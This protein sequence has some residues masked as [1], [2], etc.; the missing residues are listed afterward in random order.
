MYTLTLT[1]LAYIVALDKHRNFSLAAE[2]CHVTQPTLSM[3]VQKLEED[4]GLILFDRSERPI[5]PTRIG[6]RVIAQARNVLAETER[7][8]AIAE[9]ATGEMKG[10]LR[11]GIISTL[12]PYLLPL[13]ITPFARRYPRVSLVFEEHVAE[14]ITEYLRRD[15]LDVGLV[16][17]PAPESGIIEDPLFS[18]P[19]VGY[20]SRA[21]RLYDKERITVDDLRTDQ[22]WLMPDGHCFRD[23][24]TQSVYGGDVP[25]WSERAV[26]FESGNLETLQRLVDRGYG[27]TLLPWLAVQG[28]GSSAPDQVRAFEGETPSRT[29]RLV[30]SKTLVKR[31]MVEAFAEETRKAVAP[32]LPSGSLLREA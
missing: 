16:A 3:Q 21:H 5:V 31:H 22:V 8:T 12:A 10:V 30:Y 32:V 18:E 4:L 7:L 23:Q 17:T 24:V 29:V 13:V 11:V 15:L 20:V 6:A 14:K 27:M 1:Q 2:A 19:F 26:Q 28:E 25:E 9:E